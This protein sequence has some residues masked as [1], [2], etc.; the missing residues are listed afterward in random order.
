MLLKAA[1]CLAAMTGR[2]PVILAISLKS[3]ILSI[4]EETSGS[5]G[6]KSC[7]SIRESRVTGLFSAKTRGSFGCIG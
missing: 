5:F 1:I 3:R 4:S 2:Y 7:C 6:S